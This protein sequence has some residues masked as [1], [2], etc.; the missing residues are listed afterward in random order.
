LKSISDRIGSEYFARLSIGI[1]QAPEKEIEHFHLPIFNY[2]GFTL[3]SWYLLNKFP[4]FEIDLMEFVLL[5]EIHKMMERAFE[6]SDSEDY[7]QQFKLTYRELVAKFHSEIHY[8]LDS[9]LITK[10]Q[11]QQ[12]RLNPWT[13]E[14]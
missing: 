7:F 9:G 4:P 8:R 12:R 13:T 6:V 3:K 2:D 10:E 14:L 1:A 11:L 5:P